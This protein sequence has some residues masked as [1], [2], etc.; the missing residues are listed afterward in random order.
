MEL[1]KRT[2]Q[3]AFLWKT[4]LGLLAVFILIAVGLSL[5]TPPIAPD[6]GRSQIT[7]EEIRDLIAAG[8]DSTA[9]TD[10]R[11]ALFR[12]HL[13]KERDFER[14]MQQACE[15]V[16]LP[17]VSAADVIELL[18]DADA[19]AAEQRE[20]IAL[21]A[22]GIDVPAAKTLAEDS[23]PQLQRLQELSINTPEASFAICLL[24][25]HSGRSGDAINTGKALLAR[26]ASTTLRRWLVETAMRAER[27]HDVRAF[28][29]D[30]SFAPYITHGLL[31]HIAVE[32]RDWAEV[33]RQQIPASYEFSDLKTVMLALVA[34]AVWTVILLRMGGNA[35]SVWPM[36]LPALLLGALSAHATVF[37]IMLQET[38]L[39]W[40]EGGDML[41]Q[42][43]DEVAGTGLRE[44]TLKLLFF[45][46]LVPFLRNR[47][48]DLTLLV[49]ASLVGLGFAIE[50]NI[51]YFDAYGDSLAIT[52][53]VTANFLHISLTGLVGLAWG[54]AVLEGGDHWA[55]AVSMLGLAILLHGAYN[56]LM[57]VPEFGDFSLFS[58]TT[59]VITGRFFFA[60][61][62]HS[63]NRWLD[64]ISASAVFTW[65]IITVIG[66]ALLAAS[67]ELG[68]IYAFDTVGREFLAVGVI[69]FMF[70]QE[71]PETIT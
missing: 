49:V 22:K 66:C 18:D 51:G 45:L 40:F 13:A 28:A 10:L 65:G 69:L 58:M 31:Q 27:Y 36:A 6:E 1:F 14:L 47:G 50:E 16:T 70:Y 56:A 32:Q 12:I 60:A 26:H 8:E 17:A 21:L 7:P 23:A 55:Q 15:L 29:A 43:A 68:L 44:E 37:V 3:R 41:R 35:T 5:V 38:Y 33:A 54:R 67:N 46:P 4:S 2:R 39:G 57:S 24:L 71:I 48:D 53:F 9:E 34:G 19:M 20:V 63:R 52:R 30:A 61:L 64:P 59:F 42:I 62:R 25:E 11:L